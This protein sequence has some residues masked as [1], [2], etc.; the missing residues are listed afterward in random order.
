M[1]AASIFEHPGLLATAIAEATDD[2]MFAKDLA[3]RYR[4]ANPATLAALGR[5]TE[6]VLGRTDAEILPDRD[7]AR[8]LMATDQEV[9]SAGQ[10]REIEETVP[11]PDGTVR[12]WLTRKMP[13]HGESGAIVGVLGIARDITQRKLAE[14]QRAATQLKLEMGIQAAGLVMAEID[15]RTNLNHISGE[16][17]RM[18]ELGEGP[19]TVPRQA[20]FDR[21]HPEDRDRY[22]REIGRTLDPAGNG[23]LAIDVRALLPSGIVRWLHIR[24]QVVFAMI[25]G[26]LQ[27]ERG[28]CAAREV[29]TEMVAERKLRAAQR[30]T[31]SVIEGAGALVYAK[32]LQ[33]RYILSNQAWRRLHGLTAEQAQGITDE[34]IF[35]AETAARLRATDR[36]VIE[37]GQPVIAQERAM[38]G[39]QPT[40]FR[41][42]KLTSPTWWRR[43][44]ARTSSSPRWRT[45][46][47][48]RWHRSAPGW[49]SCAASASCRPPRNA[50]AR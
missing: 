35:G 6:D 24:L 37:E 31:L 33:G 32:D 15:Y 40:T 18:L 17:A 21:I 47:A 45:S 7:A 29:T 48:I 36:A 13:L 28:I 16:L 26:R 9:M 2:V 49:R 44:A 4:F 41:S 8:Q 34:Q 50:P 46:C 3:G 38:L 27:P 20:I 5:S 25:D 30:L 10:A 11:L 12:H 43:T 42:S 39:G 14:A 19:L 23:H 1:S 22:L